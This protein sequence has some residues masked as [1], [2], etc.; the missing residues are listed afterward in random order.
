MPVAEGFRFQV[1]GVRKRGEVF[2]VQGSGGVLLIALVIVLL[3]G[4]GV[5]WRSDVMLGVE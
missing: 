1:S 3:I 4:L 2:S 5:V